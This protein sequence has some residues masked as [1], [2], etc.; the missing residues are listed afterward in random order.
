MD[1]LSADEQKVYDT[2]GDKLWHSTKQI[3]KEVGFSNIKKTL[4][5]LHALNSLWL[6]ELQSVGRTLDGGYGYFWRRTS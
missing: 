3:M 4:T 1:T 6:V 2:L 5:S